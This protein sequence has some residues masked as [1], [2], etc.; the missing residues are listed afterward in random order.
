T[1]ETHK[2]REY[3]DRLKEI[4]YDR[5][6]NLTITLDN[7]VSVINN[8]IINSEYI[9]LLKDI[10]SKEEEPYLT[11]RKKITRLTGVLPKWIEELRS[12]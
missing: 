10:L 1:Y 7:L 6:T 9:D 4:M 11:L 5:A 3:M 2:F 8:V 12:V